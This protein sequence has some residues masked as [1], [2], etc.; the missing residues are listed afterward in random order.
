MI[1]AITKYLIAE[2]Y[3]NTAESKIQGVRGV[4]GE[5]WVLTCSVVW[6]EIE[7]RNLHAFSLAAGA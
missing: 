2:R 7:R 1:F 4:R 6:T 3:K 5:C